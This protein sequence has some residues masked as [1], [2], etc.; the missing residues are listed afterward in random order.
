MHVGRN[1]VSNLREFMFT[2]D[3]YY[4]IPVIQSAPTAVATRAGAGGASVARR[5]T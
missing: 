5:H 2:T 4:L 3:Y 1:K